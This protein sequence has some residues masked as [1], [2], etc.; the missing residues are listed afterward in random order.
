MKLCLNM[1][2]KNEAERIERCLTSVKPWISCF[3]ITDTGS[4]DDTKAL[5]HSALAGLYGVIGN[6]E[7][8]DFSQARNNALRAAESYVT[9]D[10]DY[11]LLVD[12]DME[13]K[14]E[15]P[16]CFDNLTANA[17]RLTQHNCGLFYRNI[18]LVK[19]TCGA[20][21]YGATHEYIWVPGETKN[22]DGAW[23]VD[24]ADGANREDKFSRDLRLL[25]RDLEG[26]PANPRAHFYRA[27]TLKDMGRIK[28]AVEAYVQRAQMGGWE[29]EVAYSY[30]QASRCMRLL[31]LPDTATDLALKAYEARPQR[32]EALWE[33]VPYFFRRGMNRT[34]LLFAE[35]AARIPYPDSDTLFVE[36]QVYRDA[37]A[38][39]AMLADR[40]HG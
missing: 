26:D 5:I 37:E 3:A 30:L 1:I 9:L 24:H 4:T 29:E 25:D 17:Y 14:V 7:F 10:Y 34:A 38:W 23:L 11:L 20:R 19:R 12:A 22:L 27:Q 31:G 40:S 13:L 8:R 15:D 36:D 6:D 28:E 33:L 16:A 39:L 32:A 35:V 21:Y 18:R 2:V